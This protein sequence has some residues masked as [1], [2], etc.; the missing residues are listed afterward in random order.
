MESMLKIGKVEEKIYSLRSECPL[1]IPQLD[2]DKQ[3]ISKA[4]KILN[5]LEGMGVQHIAIGSSLMNPESIQEL[6]D[7]VIKDFEM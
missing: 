4:T 1:L 5:K 7:V 2:P 6:V 3:N